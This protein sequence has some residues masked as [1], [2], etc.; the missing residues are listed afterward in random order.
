MY[1][2]VLF[3]FLWQW[4]SLD[5]KNVTW[6]DPFT[7]S[8]YLLRKPNTEPVQTTM[9]VLVLISAFPHQTMLKNCISGFVN[10]KTASTVER[11]TSTITCMHQTF[12]RTII[13]PDTT[14]HA[15]GTK[16]SRAF[17]GDMFLTILCFYNAAEGVVLWL[18][19]LS[20]A[21][22]ANMAPNGGTN[23]HH[24][25]FDCVK[26]WTVAKEEMTFFQ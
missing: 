9:E 8:L 1:T 5:H 24:L 19:A 18:R 16:K 7:L 20:L 25:N 6:A 21:I 13:I 11:K 15:S 14:L 4:W 10:S 23:K 22:S 2:F 17:S 26:A 12:F 3:T